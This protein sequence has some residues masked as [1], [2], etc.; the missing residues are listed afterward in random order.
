MN[1]SEKATQH[2]GSSLFKAR[3][4]TLTWRLWHCVVSRYAVY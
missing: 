1:K 4:Y 2:F 3:I